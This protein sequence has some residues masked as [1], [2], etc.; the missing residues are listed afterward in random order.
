[1]SSHSLKMFDSDVTVTRNIVDVV[2]P[3]HTTS[4]C[5]DENIRNLYGEHNQYASCLRC[6][7]LSRIG[8]KFG[9]VEI[10]ISPVQSVVKQEFKPVSEPVEVKVSK[11]DPCKKEQK[12]KAQKSDTS[13]VSTF[14]IGDYVVVKAPGSR[15]KGH[16][17]I[18]KSIALRN[19]VNTGYCVAIGGQQHGFFEDEL[20]KATTC[21]GD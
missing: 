13:F 3:L 5:D 15:L 12:V 20:D 21:I 8:R 2:F 4:Y 7:F 11:P 16:V 18:I 14:S 6:F 1:M 19:P 9:E 17:G 10:S